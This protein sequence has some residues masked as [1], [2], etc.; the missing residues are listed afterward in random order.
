MRGK[1]ADYHIYRDAFLT[2]NIFDKEE[3]EEMI[4]LLTGRSSFH[5]WVCD[6]VVIFLD[7]SIMQ[8]VVID[9]LYTLFISFEYLVLNL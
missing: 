3:K 8:F 7:D 1:P 9:Y 2:F 6:S 4:P 5:L